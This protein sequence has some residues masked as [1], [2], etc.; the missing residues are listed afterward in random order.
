MDRS[1]ML[2]AAMAALLFAVVP[3]GAEPPP[4]PPPPELLSPPDDPAHGHCLTSDAGEGI[5]LRWRRPDENTPDIVS[6]LEIRRGDGAG[7]WHP[8]VKQYAKPPFT[9]TAR[10]GLYAWRVWAV[11]RTGKAQPYAS[12]SAWWLFCTKPVS[13]KTQN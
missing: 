13:G 8:W 7:A 3:A 4:A 5:L 12:P 10:P 6:Y 11:D 2:S 1:R 9:L